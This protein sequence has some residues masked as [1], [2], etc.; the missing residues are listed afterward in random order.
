LLTRNRSAPAV[1]GG[2]PHIKGPGMARQEAT[3]LRLRAV[4]NAIA[5]PSG[6]VSLLR[7]A[8]SRRKLIEIDLHPTKANAVRSPSY[9]SD[10]RT[11]PTP[12]KRPIPGVWWHTAATRVTAG[13]PALGLSPAGR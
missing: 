1:R 6:S 4:A 5:V 11:V 9:D 13:A 3:E 8:T 12:E 2:H 7:G 10:T